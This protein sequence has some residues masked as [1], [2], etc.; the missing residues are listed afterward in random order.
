MNKPAESGARGASVVQFGRSVPVSADG[1][2]AAPEP[3]GFGLGNMLKFSSEVEGEP[4]PQV[5]TVAT[6]LLAQGRSDYALAFTDRLQIVIKCYASG[7]ENYLHAHSEEDHSF[8][9]LDGEATFHGPKGKI[10]AFTRNQGIMIPRGAFYSFQSSG[11]SPLVLLRVG[12]PYPGNRMI[13]F[14]GHEREVDPRDKVFPEAIP[15]EGKY[16]R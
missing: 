15:I 7:G 3:A 13:A 12:V 2:H 4:L 14:E 16:Y 11:N 5:F 10:G 8:I 1:T 6:Q 9:V